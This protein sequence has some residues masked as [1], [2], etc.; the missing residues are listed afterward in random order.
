MQTLEANDEKL[1]EIKVLPNAIQPEH[2]RAYAL[3]PLEAMNIIRTLDPNLAG[4]IRSW[5]NNNPSQWDTLVNQPAIVPQNLLDILPDECP[6]LDPFCWFSTTLQ[7]RFEQFLTGQGIHMAWG[8]PSI[9]VSVLLATANL[10]KHTH[11]NSSSEII[12]IGQPY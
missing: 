5:A 6:F 2:I 7:D 8:K 4:R 11:N 10:E 9:N 12:I 3:P 1:I